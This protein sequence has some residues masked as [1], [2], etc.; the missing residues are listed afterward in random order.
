MRILY[1][2][3]STLEAMLAYINPSGGPRIAYD[4][5]ALAD[6][7]VEKVTEALGTSHGSRTV[8]LVFTSEEKRLNEQF[9]GVA[10]N[11]AGIFAQL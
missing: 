5:D 7:L 2:T 9:S 6:A 4:D 11:I 3:A 8:T 1:C 10:R